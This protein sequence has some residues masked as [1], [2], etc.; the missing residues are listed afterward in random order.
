MKPEP[1]PICADVGP[2]SID[3]TRLGE[4]AAGLGLV[5]LFLILLRLSLKLV[6]RL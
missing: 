2:I 5:L 6:G 3:T 1:C 4:E